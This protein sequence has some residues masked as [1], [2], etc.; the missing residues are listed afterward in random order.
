MSNDYLKVEPQIEKKFQEIEKGIKVDKKDSQIKPS[1]VQ[2]D[3]G[4]R[5]RK[6]EKID[7][8]VSFTEWQETIKNNFPEL[9]S[10][11]EYGLSIMAQI[12]IK[13]ITNPFALVLVDVPSS[14]KTISIN[15]FAEI[16]GL[17]YATDK[18]TPASFVSNASN[19]K[20]EELAKI[21]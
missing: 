14:G 3:T 19:V 17:T 21:D 8:E 12:L 6:I 11:S 5:I 2:E 4:R 9:L 18:I 1:Q 20:R 16:E 13:E 10:P 15:F 7:K